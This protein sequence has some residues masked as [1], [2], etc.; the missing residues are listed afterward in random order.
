MSTGHPVAERL[1]GIALALALFLVASL[2]AWRALAAADFLFPLW[3]DWMGID[4]TIQVYAPQNRFRHGFETTEKR[5]R[6]R[7]FSAIVTAIHRQGAGL[8]ALRYHARDGQPLGHFLTPPE[9]QHLVDVARLIDRYQQL[10]WGSA[11]LSLLLLL[12]LRRGR[13]RLPGG[14]Q[15]LLGWLTLLL[16]L[17][18]LILAMGAERLFYLLH[19]WVF[20]AGHQ[21]FFYY[22]DSLMSMLM[23]APNLFAY[24][25]VVW[26]LLS[27]LAYLLLLWLARRLL[28]PTQTG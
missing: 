23:Q 3:Y 2:L 4:Q 28:A 16:T 24:I 13:W 20:P 21:W 15:L 6:L 12:A 9:Q 22:Q 5:E 27:L 25:A 11:G 8:G 26:L 7:L 1:L 14:Q 19:E 10:A 17:A 18:L